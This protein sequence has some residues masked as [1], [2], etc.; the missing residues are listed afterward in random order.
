M[1]LPPFKECCI[2][3]LYQ[4]C[5]SDFKS[6]IYHLSKKVVLP[7]CI[8]I[9]LVISSHALTTFHLSK[10]VVLPTCISIVLVISS[11]A[12]TTFHHSNNVV[13]P[14][15]ISIVLVISSHALT[16]FHRML[17]YLPVSALS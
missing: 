16:T 1:H 5:L 17:Y 10:N 6:C 13:L 8:S 9:V 7:T 2:T 14:T 3:Y 15:C 4:H 12:L 11:H